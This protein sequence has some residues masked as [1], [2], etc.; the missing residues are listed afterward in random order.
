VIISQDSV[1]LLDLYTKLGFVHLSN[2][3]GERQVLGRTFWTF[4]LPYFGHD[5]TRRET[6]H[7]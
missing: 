1:H 3:V 5:I 4:K 2:C 7:V 6:I